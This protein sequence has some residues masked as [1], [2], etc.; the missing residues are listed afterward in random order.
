MLLPVATCVPWILLLPLI[1]F[2]LIF[3]GGRVDVIR[4]MADRIATLIMAVVALLSANVFLASL[5]TADPHWQALGPEWVMR[6]WI[7]QPIFDA[8]GHV[9]GPLFAVGLMVDHLTAAMLL[10]VAWV[11]FFVHL[12]SIGYMQGDSRYVRFFC[13]LQIFTFAMLGLVLSDNLLT[14]YFFWEIMGFA[15]YSLIGHYYEKPSAKAACL[16][17]FLTTRVGDVLMF[18]GIMII[19][20]QTGSVRF[21]EI[22]A[23]VASGS[24]SEAWRLWAGLLLFCGAIGKSAQFPLHV[25]LPDAMEGPTPVSA[26]IHAATMVAAGVYLVARSIVIMTPETL[27]LIAYVGAFTALFAATMAVVMD[28]IKKVLAYSTISQLGYMMLG[29]GLAGV[30][31][32]GYAYGTYHL[33]THAFFKACLFLGS[34]SIIHAMHH[35][36]RMSH[37]GGL[38]RKMPLTAATFLYATCCL[39]GLPFV[40]S[41]FY[42]KDGIIASAIE[43]GWLTDPRHLL[44]PLFALMGA[45]FTVFYMFRVIYLTFTGKPRDEH[46]YA[47]AHESPLTMTIPLVVLALV[48]A[49]LGGDGGAWFK[50]RHPTPQAAHYATAPT[51]LAHAGSGESATMSLATG[52]A[53]TAD[54]GDGHGGDDD[55]HGHYHE[56]HAI[57]TYGSIGIVL[58]FFVL[59]SLFYFRPVRVFSPEAVAKSA[60]GVQRLL[61]NKYYVDEFYN[62]SIIQPSLRLFEFIG[63]FDSKVIDGAVNATGRAGRMMA[64]G[65]GAFDQ[66]VVDGTVNAAGRATQ[67]WGATISRLQDGN[68][69]HYLMWLVGGLSL[70]V[71]CFLL[72]PGELHAFMAAV[73]Y[74]FLY[75]AETLWVWIIQPLSNFIFGLGQVFIRLFSMLWALFEALVGLFS[76]AGQGIGDFFLWMTGNTA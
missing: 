52:A 29:L 26:L 55:H 46:A 59:A 32:Y 72:F 73:G 44:L 28:D 66:R 36:Q 58:G 74:G 27:L 17:A 56:A 64:D 10:V 7:V 14:L 35:E 53:A 70:L 68:L 38:G 61:L 63:L 57:A 6:G 75:V 71:V 15:S 34:G 22:N 45:C 48:A 50:H 23:S 69:R 43:F 21:A 54:S 51:G 5:A 1:G 42:S 3:L 47:H 33:M 41:G 13:I 65:V 16:K 19:W 8:A 31:T 11:S 40:T 20:S 4:A 62:R 60:P 9:V 2:F 18:V 25:W 76:A 37:Y 67:S 30:S 49:A 39:A 24:F 12:F